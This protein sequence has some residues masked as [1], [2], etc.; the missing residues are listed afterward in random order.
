MTWHE[1]WLAYYRAKR[2]LREKFRATR[3]R[4][5]ELLIGSSDEEFIAAIRVGAEERGI[6]R[7]H[8]EREIARFRGEHHN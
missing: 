4:L 1:F 5:D 8:V 3:E 7:D 2:W 6:S